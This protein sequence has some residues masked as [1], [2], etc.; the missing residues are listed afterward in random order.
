[1]FFNFINY[2]SPAWYFNLAP[3][4]DNVPYLLDYHLLSEDEKK[5][6]LPDINFST[7][8]VSKLDAAYQAFKKGIV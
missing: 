3:T 1:M 2:I 4:Q 5:T 6:V 7:E 8:Y